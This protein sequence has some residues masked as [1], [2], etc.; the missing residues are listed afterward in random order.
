MVF[1]PLLSGAATNLPQPCTM[2]L[3]INDLATDKVAL[4]LIGP[5]SSS[6]VF[7]IGQTTYL[8]FLVIFLLCLLSLVPFK[9]HSHHSVFHGVIWLFKY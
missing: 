4:V 9:W 5:S 1:E 6:Y 8:P 3:Y 7:L 2:D